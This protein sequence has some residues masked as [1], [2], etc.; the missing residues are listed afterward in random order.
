MDRL[1]NYNWKFIKNDLEGLKINAISTRRREEE[2]EEENKTFTSYEWHDHLQVLNDEKA[3]QLCPIGKTQTTN[4]E[5]EDKTF[6]VVL[7]MRKKKLNDWKV[8]LK[9]PIMP[10]TI[11]FWIH[12]EALK[13]YVSFF[14]VFSSEI[15]SRRG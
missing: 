14:L 7:Q 11:L 2:E 1:H 5:K 15:E 13:V 3:I 12:I 6:I 10:F 4:K 8:V 9:N